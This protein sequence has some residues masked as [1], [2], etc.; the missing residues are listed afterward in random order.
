MAV[1][2]NMFTFENRASSPV[3]SQFCPN[4]TPRIKEK[5]RYD[6]NIVKILCN[7]YKWLHIYPRCPDHQI[8]SLP[9]YTPTTKSWCCSYT[10]CNN[11]KYLDPYG[12][13]LPRGLQMFIKSLPWICSCF[14]IDEGINIFKLEKIS[15]SSN[16]P[17]LSVE[18]HLSLFSPSFTNVCIWIFTFIH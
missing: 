9:F 3:L 12:I 6:L 14:I 16:P 15:K 1:S 5:C 10:Y 11:L 4:K 7:T 13:M 18:E 2:V 8:R 17:L